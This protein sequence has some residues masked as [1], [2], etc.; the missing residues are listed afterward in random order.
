M[1]FGGARPPLVKATLNPPHWDSGRLCS[2]SSLEHGRW[3]QSLGR[4]PLP[5]GPDICAQETP[6]NTT[7]YEAMKKCRSFPDGTFPRNKLAGSPG[8]A[9]G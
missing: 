6:L 7:H 8:S 4:H 5:T 9:P 3:S 1:R 2:L